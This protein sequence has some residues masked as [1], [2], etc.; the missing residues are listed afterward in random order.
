MIEF[1]TAEDGATQAFEYVIEARGG[2]AVL[3]FVHR[4]FLGDSWEDCDFEEL[5][6]CGWD[7]YLHTLAEY[8][9]HFRTRRATYV[10]AE[11]PPASA[12]ET[13]WPVLIT[14]LGLTSQVT[15]GD[16]VLLTPR[17]VGPDRRRDGFR[18][19]QP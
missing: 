14:A 3:R 12:K 17:G 6:G 15:A 5:T 4:G 11:A 18:R 1:P 7:M 10:E 13:A 9:K 16:S 19:H 2:H 8:L